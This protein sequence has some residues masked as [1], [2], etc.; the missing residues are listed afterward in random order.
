M[1]DWLRW[2]TEWIIALQTSVAGAAAVM[3]GL[4]TLGS[5]LFFMLVMPALLWCFRASLGL[6][7]GL[8]LLTSATLNTFFKL[9]LGL[10]RPFWADPRVRALAVETSFGLPSGHA[11]N[12]V[13]L[14]GSLADVVRRGWA[15]ALA[16]VLVV[17][18]SLSRLYLGVHYPADVVSGWL[19]GGLLLLAGARWTRPFLR[20]FRARSVGARLAVA[21][22]LSIALFWVGWRLSVVA[23]GRPLPAEWAANFARAA[24]PGVIF[25]PASAEGIVAATGALLGFAVG[26]VLLDAWGGFRDTSRA[27][28]RAARFVVGLIGVVALQLGLGAVL[29]DGDA[30]RYLRYAAV[31][32]WIAYGA[33]R[34]FAAL[35]LDT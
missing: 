21:G 22:G 35:R 15:T 20:W 25:Q 23:T 12:A 11:Q 31:A 1:T 10:P 32:F 17:G 26:A 8:A 30:F 28:P 5:E 18:I 2:G 34:T 24:G 4:T 27:W 14:W 3:D 19:I 7:L 33:P 13:V 16:A 6:R 29:P 9:G